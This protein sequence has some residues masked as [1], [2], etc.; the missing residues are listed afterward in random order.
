MTREFVALF[1]VWR[2]RLR[3]RRLLAAMGERERQDMGSCWSEIAH[4]VNKPFWL[5]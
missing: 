5:K 2:E 3:V 4:E 1:R